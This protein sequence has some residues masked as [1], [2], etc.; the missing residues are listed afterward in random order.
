MKKFRIII[1]IISSLVVTLFSPLSAHAS[2]SPADYVGQGIDHYDTRVV[3]AGGGSGSLN[4]SGNVEKIY[5]YFAGKG[6]NAAAIS[7][8]LGNIQTESAQ[9][10]SPFQM[11][12]TY[13]S[14]GIQA[15]LPIEEHPEKDKALGLIQWDSGRRQSLLT[16][17]SAKYPDFATTIDTYGRSADT[18]KQAPTPLNDGYLS[19]ELDFLYEELTSGYVFWFN[20][21]KNTPNT[22]DGARTA[23]EV[24]NR[25]VEVSGDYSNDRADQAAAFFSQ[26]S[27]N[28]PSNAG[29]GLV[30]SADPSAS[31]TC[32]SAQPAGDVVYYS[33]MDPKW[34][35]SP[36]AGTGPLDTIANV[37]C[38]PTSMAIILASLYDKNITPP[39]VA[40]V[41]GEQHGG[42]SNWANLINGVN[43]KWGLNISTSNLSWSEAVDFVKSGKGYVW[44]GG[45]GAPPFTKSGHLVAIVGVSSDGSMVTVA[46]PDTPADGHEK[47]KEYPASQIQSQVGGLFGV[48]KK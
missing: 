14:T 10:Y 21:I 45:S 23:A 48:P 44:A 11:Q 7:A 12:F 8:M 4:G 9:S 29:G 35:D 13:A 28:P 46:D 1:S 17:I 26:F 15:V 33:Q 18:A 25:H 27:A 22:V 20:E 36:Y 42:T 5:N 34:A 41:A 6:L 16:A 24:W 37:G 2:L 19:L 3:C 47:I 31:A 30:T 40:A 43:A 39:D 38:G 32:V